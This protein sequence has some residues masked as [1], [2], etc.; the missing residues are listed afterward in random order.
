MGK[1][2]QNWGLLTVF[3]LTLAVVEVQPA[4]A[5][6]T[7][8]L[9]IGGGVYDPVTETI[10]STSDTFTL[11]AILFPGRTPSLLNDTYYIAAAIAPKI[12]PSPV[13]LGN[14]TFGGNSVDVTADM[15]YGVPPLEGTLA[16][17]DFRDLASHG[18]YDTYFTEFAFTFNPSNTARYYNTQTHPGGL[19]PDSLASELVYY[20]AFDIDISGLSSEYNVHFDLFNTK[21]RDGDIDINNFAPFSHDAEGRHRVPEPSSLLLMGIGLIGSAGWAYRRSRVL[22]SRSEVRPF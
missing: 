6:P 5:I 2:S 22:E 8:Q 7:L 15:T 10:V 1:R 14:F 16:T 12:G 3:A 4:W 18:I 17:F 19:R 13:S 21:V 9:D 11:F 20:A